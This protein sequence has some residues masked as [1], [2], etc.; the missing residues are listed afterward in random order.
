MAHGID[1][2]MED[3]RW[4]DL[5]PLAL[6]AVGAVLAQLHVAGEVAVLAADDARIAALNARFRGKAAPTNV[7]SWPSEERGATQ[8]GGEPR[9]PEG[10]E[11]GDIALA[12]ETCAREA[13]AQGKAFEAHVT[14]L[15][16]HGTLHLLGYDH[17][18]DA[19]AAL[20]ERLEV[21]I[22]GNLGLADPYS[23]E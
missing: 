5:E 7:L 9:M 1:I 23:S 14:H 10:S 18:T 15:I 13:E 17:E 16:V 2:I 8:P 22:L 19:D 6:R 20:M 11:L 21:E 3:A 12:Y 4:G